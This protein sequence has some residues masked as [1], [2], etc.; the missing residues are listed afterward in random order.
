MVLFFHSFRDIDGWVHMQIPHSDAYART[1]SSLSKNKQKRCEAGTIQ[2]TY[3][4]QCWLLCSSTSLGAQIFR[5]LWFVSCS[6]SEEEKKQDKIT[7][8]IMGTADKKYLRKFRN[9][10]F[11]YFREYVSDETVERLV[12][13]APSKITFSRCIPFVPW[14]RTF[15]KE[16]KKTA[17]L[18]NKSLQLR[19]LLKTG[20]IDI[21]YFNYF[22]IRDTQRVP[23]I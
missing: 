16:R 9:D 5:F 23:H 6:N 18:K 14:G 10:R 15:Q 17:A 19:F 11:E 2:I 21:R 13:L 8:V 4:A 3:P 12:Y 20:L 1:R 7:A 22:A